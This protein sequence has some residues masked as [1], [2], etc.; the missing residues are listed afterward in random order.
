MTSFKIFMMRGFEERARDFLRAF[1]AAADAGALLTIHAE[2]EHLIGYCTER[3]LAA[4]NRERRAF[5]GQPAAAVRSRGRVARPQDDGAYR[6]ARVL[7]ASVEQS[8]D[9]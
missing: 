5:R 3:L 2:D 6:R 4:G 7:R 9:R 1:E 8:R